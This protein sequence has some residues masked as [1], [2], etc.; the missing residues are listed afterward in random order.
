M[1]PNKT[2]FDSKWNERTAKKKRWNFFAEVEVKDGK[3]ICQNVNY[4]IDDEIC[5]RWE[6]SQ[7][8]TFRSGGTYEINPRYSWLHILLIENNR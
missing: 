5:D 6:G 4:T 7:N 2:I 1:E 3:L 8:C